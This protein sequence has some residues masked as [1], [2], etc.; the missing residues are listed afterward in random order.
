VIEPLPAATADLLIGWPKAALLA[1][2]G[3]IVYGV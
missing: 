3:G 1:L 2:V